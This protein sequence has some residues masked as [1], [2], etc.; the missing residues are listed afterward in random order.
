M[1]HDLI[2]ASHVRQLALALSAS[3]RRGRFTRVSAE[4]LAHVNEQVRVIVT[5]RVRRHP[6]LGKTLK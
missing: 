6:S 4:F 1:T 5:D 2:H 3:E